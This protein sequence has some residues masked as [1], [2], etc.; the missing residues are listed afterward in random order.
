MVTGIRSTDA[1]DGMTDIGRGLRTGVPAGSLLVM[2][3][4][5]SSPGIGKVTA[6]DSSTTTVGIATGTAIGE[7]GIATGIGIGVS[8]QTGARADP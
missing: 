8:P 5:S 4:G 2:T 7:I 6:A 3:G 1:T